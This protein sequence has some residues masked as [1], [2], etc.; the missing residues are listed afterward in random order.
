MTD[1]SQTLLVER[2]AD[3]VALVRLNRP[4]VRNALNLALRRLLA[5][6]F[7]TL[8]QDPTVRV[9]VLTGNA[10]AFCAGA[11]LNEYRDAGTIEVLQRGL[12]VLWGAIA[13][14]PKPVIAAVNG[15][16]LGGGCELA[17]LADIIIAGESARFGQPEV[18]L[19]LMPGA[20]GTQ[21]FARVAGKYA[22][23]KHLLTGQPWTAR[24]ALTMGLASAVVEDSAV[25]P[26]ALSL[27]GDV[28]AVAP[29]AVRQIKELVL[30]S[31]NTGLDA[32]LRLEHKAFQILFSSADKREGI[33]AFLEKRK[34]NFTGQ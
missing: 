10:E 24:E 30:E 20:G 22:A 16:A 11:D 28:A 14:C 4:A 19:G 26:T 25:L 15:P 31:M 34:P 8:G 5:E 27:A 3:H 23:M 12:Q 29:L 9:I 7:T 1:Q 6:T 17:L 18:K 2:P 21:R 32:G 13:A 33:A